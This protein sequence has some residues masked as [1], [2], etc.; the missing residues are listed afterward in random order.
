MSALDRALTWSLTALALLG[1][2]AC[3]YAY[4]QLARWLL[5]GL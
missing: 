4:A 5:G 3:L 1:A 2:V